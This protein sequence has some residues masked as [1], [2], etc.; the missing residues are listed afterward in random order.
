MRPILDRR[1][2]LAALRA[3]LSDPSSLSLVQGPR[4]V[5]KTFL[6]RHL[7]AD[8][9]DAFYFVADESTGPAL[10]ARFA[11]DLGSRG[12][13]PA[14][15]ADWSV[16]L[17]FLLQRTALDGRRLVLVLDEFQYL[18]TAVPALPS[19]L[20][21]L[22]DEFHERMR[23]HVIL[24]G[25]ALSTMTRL[26]DV[27]QP[28][29]GRFDLRLPLEP[30]GYREAAE[31]APGWSRV[32]RFRLFG[33][34]G[35]VARHLA[36]LRPE[37]TLRDNATSL[38]LDP[39]A[40]L[41]E[42]PLDLLRAERP[43]KV[44]DAHAVLT[45]IARGENR[46][47]QIAARTGLT[48]ARTDAVLGEL[49]DLRVLRRELRFDDATGS[50]YVRYRCADPLTRFWFRF[51][52]PNRSVLTRVE[53]E[54]VWDERIAPLQDDAMGPIWEEIVRMGV[55][56]G[57][58]GA[59]AGV[60][61]HRAAPWWGRDGQHEIDLVVESAAGLRFVECKWRPAGAVGVADLR[62]L[63]SHIAASPFAGRGG[64]PTLATA[65]GFT[66]ELRTLAAEGV[67]DLL[68]PGDFLPE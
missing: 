21:R 61:V 52:E 30:F 28:L 66:D 56:A 64:R 38:L 50:R 2:E 68:G 62:R 67:V 8:D 1:R 46:F 43:S 29:H 63:E 51:I 54:Q 22:W 32:E 31:F 53:P 14:L 49:Q 48:A 42:A 47:Q 36:Y 7:V 40:P 33:V 41:H 3:R 20:Q 37:R 57:V 60:A 24:C 15:P 55:E 44:S 58:L 26:G 25:S 23:L 18:L 4:R 35:G 17:T 65:G 9:P 5:G 34:F 19:I 16:L 11:A 6:L 45:S 39:L 12:P 27:A 59:E 10:A 13:G